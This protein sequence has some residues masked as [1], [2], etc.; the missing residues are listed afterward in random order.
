MINK[1]LD[2]MIKRGFVDSYGDIYDT[3]ENENDDDAGNQHQMQRYFVPADF[4]PLF[5]TVHHCFLGHFSSSTLQKGCAGCRGNRHS[6]FGFLSCS[7]Q[8]ETERTT[9]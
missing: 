8:P 9:R 1:I 4:S 5:G 3:N 6:E 7:S 2:E